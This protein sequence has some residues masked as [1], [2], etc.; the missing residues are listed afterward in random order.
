MLAGDATDYVRF[1]AVCGPWRRCC[2][3]PR[4]QGGGDPV[5]GRFLP[6]RWIMIEKSSPTA[7]RRHR[8]N[9]TTGECIHMDLPELADHDLLTV[10][11]EGLL[12][13]SHKHA[14]HGVRLLNPLTRQLTDLP[15]FA[16]M[17]TSEQL[18]DRQ[19]GVRG[20]NFQV[21]GVALADDSPCARGIMTLET[22]S[23]Q[24]PPRLLMA[25]EMVSSLHYFSAMTDSLHL[26]DNGGEL[27][28]VHRMIRPD[29][30]EQLKRKCAV[31]RV[32]G[33]IWTPGC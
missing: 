27:M 22:S 19:R 21:R 28:L 20:E 4:A 9:F 3:S 17:L 2:A 26:V 10:T 23:D 14:P 33:W 24:P 8:F 25:V 6:R 11:P 1:R 32:T 15:P 31:Y 12:L 30:D 13:L 16:T 29:G 18:S 5:D 7:P